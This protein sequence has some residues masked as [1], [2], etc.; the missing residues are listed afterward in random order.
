LGV[1]DRRLLGEMLVESGLVGRSDLETALAEQRRRGGRIGFQLMRLGKVAPGPLYLFLEEHFATLTPDLAEI[2]RTGPRVDLLPARMAHY[3]RMVPLRQD[4]RKLVLA[5]TTAD[6]PSLISALEELTDL[7]VDPLICPPCLIR[8]A[9]ERF[10][11]WEEER[12]VCRNAVGE[13]V[14]ILSD[15][16]Q[17]ITPRALD[18]LEETDTGSEW[19]RS[20]V[21]EAILR[22]SREI[23]LEPLEEEIRVA[24]RR[25]EGEESLRTLPRSLQGGIALA[26][27]QLSR[28][29]P[30]GRTVPREGRFHLRHDGRTLA[31]VV[32]ALPGL[33]GD[34]HRLSLL[35]ERIQQK[36]LSEMLE[37]YP[38]IREAL[39]R[40]LCE[41]KGLLLLAAPEGH[42]RKRILADLV[43]FLRERCG[44]EDP[45]VAPEVRTA[46]EASDLFQAAGDRLAVAGIQKADAFD[47]L[48]WLLQSDLLPP[49][50]AG[51][52]CGILGA[53]LFERSCEHC[54][55]RLDL[56]AEIPSL[57]RMLEGPDGCHA[58]VGCR[59]CRGAGAL[60]LE[61]VFEFLPGTVARALEPPSP[62]A[63]RERR[64]ELAR[65]GVK[66]LFSTAM[67]R[68]AAG[69]VD[70]RE[71]LRLL[72]HEGRGAA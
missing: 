11:E 38:G 39:Q 29:E 1:R 65:A 33:Q 53:R 57:A 28:M 19:L 72:F 18:S 71:P 27:G 49:I 45:I 42:H 59:V 68:A 6:D 60:E 56:A 62:K 54:R 32:T 23:L 9:L 46:M 20:V 10:F 35:E 12:G 37:G 36:N 64:R 26:L 8:E 67:A 4:G 2:L 41:K 51:R 30:R 15:Q 58:N 24:F 69:E 31:A 25:S 16:A 14:L 13:N 17:G 5:V 47:S 50:R 48:D 40:A 55:R 44:A 3:Y 43:G 66:T 7:T 52:L 22:R 34:A 21:A 63:S 70:V 61:P